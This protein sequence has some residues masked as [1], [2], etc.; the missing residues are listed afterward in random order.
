M[1]SPHPTVRVDVAAWA[2]LEIPFSEVAALRRQPSH[3]G[4][5]NPAQAPS[6]NAAANGAANVSVNSSA[7][8]QGPATSDSAGQSRGG[9]ALTSTLKLVDEQTVVAVTTILRAIEEA[10]WQNRSFSDWGVISAPR[11]FGRDRL[12]SGYERYQRSAVRGM[13][14]LLIPNAMLNA[15]SGTASVALGTHGMNFGV[16]G[17]SGQL[18][19]LLLVGASLLQMKQMAGLWMVLSQWDPE[20]HPGEANSSPSPQPSM[21]YGIALALVPPGAESARASFE[22]ARSAPRY[23]VIFPDDQVETERVSFGAE[24]DA[25]IANRP[26]TL[27]QDFNDLRALADYLRCPSAAGSWR[28]DLGADLVAQISHTAAAA[29]PTAA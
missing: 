15:V 12:A 24:F 2:T 20:P 28:C 26:E 11:Y 6:S 23:R 21:G 3:A 18:H 19:D 17:S 16:G 27:Q 1:S 25:S 4:I 13:S 29:L 8:A 7:A 5:S 10:G 14:P 9:R 22:I